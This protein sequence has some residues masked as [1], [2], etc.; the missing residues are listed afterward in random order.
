LPAELRQQR[1]ALKARGKR[2]SD[3]PIAR[4]R[5]TRKH[6]FGPISV[7]VLP[8]SRP[9]DSDLYQ[10]VQPHLL[11]SEQVKHFGYGV[12][13]QPLWLVALLYVVLLGVPGFFV[14]ALL[15]KHYVVAL[16]DRRLVVVRIRGGVFEISCE[17]K[18]VRAYL[19]EELG[20]QP[21]DASVGAKVVRICVG[22]PKGRPLVVRFRRGASPANRSNAV[23]IAIALGTLKE[24]GPEAMRASLPPESDVR[25]RR[26]AAPR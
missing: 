1:A 2:L 11:V 16:T 19:F 7:E 25:P 26:A 9:S 4:A 24:R 23:A 5:S 14:V 18:E 20:A 21:I 8:V 6:A 10:A 12:T 13:P 3:K 15:A 22:D 17:V